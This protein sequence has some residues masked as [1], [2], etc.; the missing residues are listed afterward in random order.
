MI[1]AAGN[2]PVK[3]R[4]PR[5]AWIIAGLVTL[6]SSLSHADQFTNPGA[7]LANMGHWVSIS[8]F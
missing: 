8:A 4:L 1:K 3:T 7:Q 6:V 5:I 2:L